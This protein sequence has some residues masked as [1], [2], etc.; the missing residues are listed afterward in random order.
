MNHAHNS[1]A[2]KNCELCTQ[3]GGELLWQD[4]RCRVI[5]VGGD[6]GTAFPGFCR[7]VWRDHIKEMSDLSAADQRHLLQVL[8]ATEVAV[9]TAVQPDK[10]N[11]A[12][13]GNMVPHLHWHVIPRWQDDSHFPGAIWAAAQR[14]IP[15]RPAVASAALQ[16]ALQQA[17]SEMENGA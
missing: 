1:T 10:I 9:R 5:R 4:E 17:L 6:D 8:L 11:L 13:F 15:V 12:S 14:P 7:V 2:S 16:A 3:P